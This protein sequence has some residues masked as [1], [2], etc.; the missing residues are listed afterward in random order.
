MRYRLLAGAIGLLLIS[1]AVDAWT[2]GD[3]FLPTS[4]SGG[5][6]LVAIVVAIGAGISAALRAMRRPRQR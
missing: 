3:V 6:L 2:R 4:A 1:C 5:A